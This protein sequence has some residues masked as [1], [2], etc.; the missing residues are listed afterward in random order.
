[1]SSG[2]SCTS[3]RARPL[4]SRIP[5]SRAS[6]SRRRTRRGARARPARRRGACPP[7]SNDSDMSGYPV[8]L[9]VTDDLRR[10]RL[11]VFFRL[12]LAIPHFIWLSL[13]SEEHTSELQS[14][15]HLVCRLL[16]EK[17]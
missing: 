12:L 13:R 17:K 10:T 8:R 16:L 15:D 3:R 5:A 11:T 6:S 9:V 14:P 4:A 2:R 1:A 7:G